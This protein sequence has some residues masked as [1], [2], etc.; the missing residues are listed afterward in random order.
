MFILPAQREFVSVEGAQFARKMSNL[1]PTSFREV[2]ISPFRY[3]DLLNAHNGI[4]PTNIDNDP[5][6]YACVCIHLYRS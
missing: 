1:E 3:N 2:G 6:I 5:P 4:T